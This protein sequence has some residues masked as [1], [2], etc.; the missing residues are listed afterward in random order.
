MKVTA[1]FASSSHSR[2]LGVRIQMCGY[3][4][5]GERGAKNLEIRR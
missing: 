1:A 5:S 2:A 3:G 4:V